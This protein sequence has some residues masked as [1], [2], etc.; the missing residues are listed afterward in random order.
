VAQALDYWNMERPEDRALLE[1][2]LRAVLA[3][4]DPA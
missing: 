2:D 1:R 4:P 3:L